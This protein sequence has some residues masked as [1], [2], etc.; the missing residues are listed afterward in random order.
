MVS[1]RSV[2]PASAGAAVSSPRLASQNT[3]NAPTTTTPEHGQGRDDPA[4]TCLTL[5]RLPLLA[6]LAAGLRLDRLRARGA[7]QHCPRAGEVDASTPRP[8]RATRHA[9]SPRRLGGRRTSSR[10]VPVGSPDWPSWRLSCPADAGGARLMRRPAGRGHACPRIGR[11]PRAPSSRRAA[12]TRRGRGC[13]ST[14]WPGRGSRSGSPRRSGSPG[15]ARVWPGRVTPTKC[16]SANSA[17]TSRQVE[18]LRESVGAGD[19][20]ELAR[21][22]G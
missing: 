16:A 2:R 9:S 18:Q 4:L 3:S 1:V 10:A 19:E 6:Q 12:R 17:S 8:I 21:C 15:S 7:R 20:E 5:L 22:S 11:R 14:R 13:R